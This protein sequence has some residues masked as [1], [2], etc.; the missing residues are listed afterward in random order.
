MG[1]FFRRNSVSFASSGVDSPVWPGLGEHKRTLTKTNPSLILWSK[2]SSWFTI[3]VPSNQ[4][5]QVP[6]GQFLSTNKNE[7][8]RPWLGLQ[9]AWRNGLGQ[10]DG[11]KWSRKL[12]IDSNRLCNI[13][14]YKHVQIYWYIYIYIHMYTLYSFFAEYHNVLYI[15]NESSGIVWH[16]AILEYIDIKYLFQKEIRVHERIPLKW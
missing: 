13:W 16:I 7:T 5:H 11:W 14:M 12:E 2:L 6:V 4:G 3:F 8:K 1:S 15:I 9:H 10:I